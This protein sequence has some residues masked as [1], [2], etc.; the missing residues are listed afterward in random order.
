M[1][2]WKAVMSGDDIAD[3]T[4]YVV[5]LNGRETDQ[6]AAA[7]GQKNYMTFCIACHGADA[8]G[9]QMFGA[10]N[11]T[12]DIWLYGGSPVWIKQTL[13]N[14]RNGKMPAQDHALSSDKIHLLTAYVYS[15]SNK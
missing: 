13:L 8:K 12:D 5:G 1:P 11:L 9:N 6:A 7:A 10:P 15:L 3:L 2:G 4:A 14:G